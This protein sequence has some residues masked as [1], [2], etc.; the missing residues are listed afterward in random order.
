MG[1]GDYT[2]DHRV[3][4]LQTVLGKDVLLILRMTAVER[5][6][7]P[8]TIVVDAVSEKPPALHTL[9]GTNAS[10]QFDVGG[11][12]DHSRWFNGQVWEYAELDRDD[13][14]YHCRLTLRPSTQFM[15]LNRRNASSRRNRRRRS[16]RR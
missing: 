1:Q 13:Q 9:L 5:L 3:A 7:E 6:S 14:G 8:F 15:T 12:P 2:Q 4:R 16:S 10:I 11:R